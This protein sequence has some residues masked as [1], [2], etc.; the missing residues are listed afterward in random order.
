MYL[1][2]NMCVFLIQYWSP[3]DKISYKTTFIT[4]LRGLYICSPVLTPTD[5]CLSENGGDMAYNDFPIFVQH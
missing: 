1:R 3:F 4:L 5:R 2:M